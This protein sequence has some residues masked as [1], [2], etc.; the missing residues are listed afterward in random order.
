MEGVEDI[1]KKIK[2]QKLQN[3]KMSILKFK[4]NI[5]KHTHNN[6]HYKTVTKEVTA[7]KRLVSQI[8][9]EHL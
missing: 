7:D 3:K 5:F 8:Y 6:R 2:K 1:L 4:V 9:E